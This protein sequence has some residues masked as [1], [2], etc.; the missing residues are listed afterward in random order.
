MK[1]QYF[2]SREK[3]EEMRS[4]LANYNCIGIIAKISLSNICVYIIQQD[5]AYEKSCALDAV[6]KDLK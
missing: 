4:Q 3:R 5:K 6:A 1:L 2:I